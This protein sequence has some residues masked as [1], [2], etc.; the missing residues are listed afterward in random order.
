MEKTN[1]FL[2]LLIFSF[3]LLPYFSFAQV[4]PPEA[5][6]PPD[7]PTRL[8]SCDPNDSLRI[9]ILK[10]LGDVLRVI[11]VIALAGAA[12]MIALAGLGYIRAG[13][14]DDNVKNKIIYAAVG[15][16]IAF[17]AWVVTV[18]LTR[19]IGGSQL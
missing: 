19:I 6:Q 15:L 4:P 3:F 5:L 16:V 8:F 18:I 17:L 14:A 1:K 7:I 9:C 2:S 13:K 10:L 12:L 11:L